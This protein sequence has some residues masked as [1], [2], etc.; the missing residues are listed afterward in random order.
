MTNADIEKV[1]E[2]QLSLLIALEK[3]VLMLSH[4]VDKENEAN[5]DA[6]YEI[7]LK[8]VGDIRDILTKQ[9]GLLD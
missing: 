2:L 7:I 4:L 6:Q 3:Q 5:F 8:N 1:F 9:P